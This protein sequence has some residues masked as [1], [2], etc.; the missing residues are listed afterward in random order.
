MIVHLKFHPRQGECL[1]VALARTSMF[2]NST[3][4]CCKGA[5]RTTYLLEWIMSDSPRRTVHKG[6]TKIERH[7]R[8]AKHL[9]FGGQ[10]P[11]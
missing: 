3:C 9:A 7:H 6:A 8:F 1:S 2:L 4:D 5:V 10:W 11:T